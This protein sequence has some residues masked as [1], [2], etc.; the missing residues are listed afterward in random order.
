VPGSADGRRLVDVG[1]DQTREVRVLVV[2]PSA[3]LPHSTKITF[4]ITDV[5]SGLEA[6]ATN[7]FSAP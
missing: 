5:A 3:A 7:F 2:S 6:Q 4:R 1:P